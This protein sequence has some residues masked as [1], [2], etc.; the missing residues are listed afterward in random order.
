[1][2]PDVVLGKA[3]LRQRRRVM[4]AVAVCRSQQLRTAHGAAGGEA[5]QVKVMVVRCSTNAIAHGRREQ[6]S[7]APNERHRR[8]TAA[9]RGVD[10]GDERIRLRAAV[11]PPDQARDAPR[12]QRPQRDDDR[13]R[14][15]YR[16]G[17]GEL[18]PQ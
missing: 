12:R 6:G 2:Q 9:R 14:Y 5:D 10:V 13:G 7:R 16:P 1:M 3:Q 18:L 11:V 8:I 17:H 15:A 4:Q